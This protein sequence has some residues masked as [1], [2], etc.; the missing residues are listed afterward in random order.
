[1]RNTQ[2]HSV[3]RELKSFR[4]LKLVVGSSSNFWGPQRIKLI[5][6]YNVEVYDSEG[7]AS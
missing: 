6:V 1:M 3:G 5:H 4:T 7:L 2:I